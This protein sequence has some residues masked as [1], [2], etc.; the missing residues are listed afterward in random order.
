L[1]ARIVAAV[2]VLIQ[3]GDDDAANTRVEL[4]ELLVGS[5]GIEKT[6][7]SQILRRDLIGGQRLWVRVKFTLCVLPGDKIQLVFDA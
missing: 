3:P 6:P 4:A 7:H 1:N 5:L 2:N